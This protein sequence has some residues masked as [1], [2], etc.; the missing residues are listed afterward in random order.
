VSDIEHPYTAAYEADGV[1]YVS[2]ALSVDAA[3]DVVGGRRTALD[4]ALTKLRSRLGTVGLDLEHIVKATYFVTDVTLR[5]EANQQFVDVF[6][7]P[8]PARSF[9]EV[10]RL[11]YGATVEIEAVARRS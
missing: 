7:E 4:A 1:V 3:G 6:A 9:V 2:G 5:D 8:R 10:S 11:P